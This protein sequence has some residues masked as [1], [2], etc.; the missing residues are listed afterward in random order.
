MRTTSTQRI[1]AQMS[2]ISDIIDTPFATRR[3]TS[4]PMD[5]RQATELLPW[6]I[7]GSLRSTESVELHQHLRSCEDCQGELR[8]T[9]EAGFLSSCHVPSFALAE[10]SMGLDPKDLSRDEISAHLEICSECR[11]DLELISDQNDEVSYRNNIET[12]VPKRR[13]VPTAPGR[14]SRAASLR[15]MFPIAAM[16]TLAVLGSLAW[17]FSRSNVR[18]APIVALEQVSVS[19]GVQTEQDSGLLLDGFE[20]GRFGIWSILEST[21]G[22]FESGTLEGWSVSIGERNPVVEPSSRPSRGNNS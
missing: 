10:Y 4:L 15:S 22:G 5:C 7:N 6:L 19:T 14:P 3:R 20:S 11:E 16:L 9:V 17:T 13:N 8:A 2:D 12:F 21:D 1:E 18:V